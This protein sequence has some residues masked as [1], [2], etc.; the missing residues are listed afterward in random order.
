MDNISEGMYVHKI[1]ECM[2]LCEYETSASTYWPK[3]RLYSSLNTIRY[4][5]SEQ[6]PMTL[7][8]NI[9]CIRHTSSLNL[10]L[11][12]SIFCSDCQ[13]G[14]SGCCSLGTTQYGISL[15][16]SSERVCSCEIC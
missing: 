16:Q 4:T 5:H 11:V 15:S 14:N 9:P 7:R 10:A 1:S 3:E 12:S 6:A 2:Q 8:Y 13:I